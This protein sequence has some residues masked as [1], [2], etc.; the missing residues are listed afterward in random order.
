MEYLAGGSLS[1]AL[2]D[3]HSPLR[4]W[5]SR[6][7]C[8]R[9]GSGFSIAMQLADALAYLHA[10]GVNSN[11]SSASTSY[12]NALMLPGL[13]DHVHLSGPVSIAMTYRR[14]FMWNRLHTHQASSVYITN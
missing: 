8:Q 6:H 3:E 11:A 1:A 4:W 7:G 10:N 2:Q 14:A 12:N 13:H 5:V 9:M